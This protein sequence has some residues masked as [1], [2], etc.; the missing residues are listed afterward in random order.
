MEHVRYNA[1]MYRH[2]YNKLVDNQGI[3]DTRKYRYVFGK[4]FADIYRL[5]ITFIDTVRVHDS[6]QFV[7]CPDAFII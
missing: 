4:S 2:I 6:W 3:F 5:P 7:D 1:K